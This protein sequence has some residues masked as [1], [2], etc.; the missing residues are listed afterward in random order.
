MNNSLVILTDPQLDQ[1]LTC[2]L[3]EEDISDDTLFY[4]MRVQSELEKRERA[5]ALNFDNATWA[6]AHQIDRYLPLAG[7][8]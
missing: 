4:L 7:R 5:K 2:L 3:I 1:M 8:A 6:E